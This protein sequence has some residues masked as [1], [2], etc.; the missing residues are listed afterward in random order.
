M[1]PGAQ[2]DKTENDGLKSSLPGD[3]NCGTGIEQNVTNR[4][5]SKKV[6]VDIL[7]PGG[8][9]GKISKKL[10][11]NAPITVVYFP[12]NVVIIPQ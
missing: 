4:P 6:N 8:F 9:G 7:P 12:D 2:G 1:T 5:F 10:Y 11:L 3:H